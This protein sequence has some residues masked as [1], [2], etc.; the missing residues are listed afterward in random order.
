MEITIKEAKESVIDVI[1]AG[2]VPFIASSP[3]IGKS[4][5]A[6][7][8]AEDFNLHMIDIRL[9]QCDPTEIND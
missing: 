9:S 1:S 5:L 8:I 2:L 6:K 3:G 4:S 7:E